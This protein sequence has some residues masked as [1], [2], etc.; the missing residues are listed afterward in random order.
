VAATMAA[1]T[2][3]FM[4]DLRFMT[5]FV[6]FSKDGERPRSEQL[7]KKEKLCQDFPRKS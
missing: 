7:Q 3:S 1:A 2:D 6:G 5:V 4:K